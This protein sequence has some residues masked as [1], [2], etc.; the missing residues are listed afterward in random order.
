[1]TLQAKKL[2]PDFAPPAAAVVRRAPVPT[3]ARANAEVT[4]SDRLPTG[5]QA[6]T[7]LEAPAGMWGY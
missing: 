3:L 1:M 7:A 2:V 4:P 5:S 6:E